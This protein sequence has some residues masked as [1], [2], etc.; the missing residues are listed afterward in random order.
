M[1][2]KYPRPAVG[3]RKR[4]AEEYQEFVKMMWRVNRAEYIS[5]ARRFGL[6]RV[7]AIIADAWKQRRFD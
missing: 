5:I 4:S 3:P 6:G 2:K 1:P 7:I